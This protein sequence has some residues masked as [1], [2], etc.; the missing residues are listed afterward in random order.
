MTQAEDLRSRIARQ[1]AMALKDP[2]PNLRF[3]A[4]EGLQFLPGVPELEQV[5]PLLNDNDR[6]VKWKAMQVAG[7]LRL[8]SAGPALVKLLGSADMNTRSYAALAL[9][10]LQSS[11]T[12]SSLVEQFGREGAAKVRQSIIRSLGTFGDAIPWDTLAQAVEDQDVGVRLDLAK[13]LGGSAPKPAACTILVS[14]IEREGNNHVF[15]T[16]ILSLGR[17]RQPTL[18]PYFQHSLM[19]QESRIRANAV[20]A[21]GQLPFA[22]VESLIA[23]HLQDPANRVKANVVGIYLQNGKVEAVRPELDKLLGSANRWER[24]SGA[25]LAGTFRL[26]STHPALVKLL[27]DEE[28][29]VAERSAWALGRLKSD[30]SF[31]ILFA[32]YQNANQ[33]ALTHIIRAIHEVARPV[34]VPWL[35]KLMEKERSPLLKS[36]LIDIFTGLREQSVRETMAAHRTD[37]DIRVRMSVYR[38]LG[39][40]APKEYSEMLLEGLKDPNQKVRGL[41]ADLMLRI[42]DLRALKTL[43]DLLNDQDK[44]QRV[45]RVST[46]RELAALSHPPGK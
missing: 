7:L 42:G 6:F 16:A 31:T 25:W 20:E 12:I 30:D 33:W 10:S 40:I 26:A 22:Q 43:S 36:Q 23:P 45:E 46:L 38:Y 44:L 28:A 5:L 11:G 41:C 37:H 19:N 39:T 13:V 3:L 27:N 4:L 1:F 9:G 14:L 21:L 35:L 8:A 32:A 18:L 17:F 34:H 2:N 24:S 29:V 15:A